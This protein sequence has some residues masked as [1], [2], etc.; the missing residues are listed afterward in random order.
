MWR[1]NYD[2]LFVFCFFL[3][4][5][6]FASAIILSDGKGT[7]V[8]QF[9]T[10]YT[11]CVWNIYKQNKAGVESDLEKILGQNSIIL[12]QEYLLNKTLSPL[13]H[14]QVKKGFWWGAIEAFKVRN[15]FPTGV[16][17]ISNF[18]PFDFFGGHSS[19]VEPITN[20]PKSFIMSKFQ[21]SDSNMHLLVI[22]NHILNFVSTEAFVTNIDQ[23]G[24]LINEHPGPAIWAG[25]FNTWN[26]AR[27]NYL[28]QMATKLGFTKVFIENSGRRV[29]TDHIYIR[30]NIETLDAHFNTEIQSSDHYP[31]FFR[32]RIQEL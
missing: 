32:F 19:L 14:A 4:N 3:L 6:S 5:T 21:I 9:N 17:T 27:M 29:P 28:N 1:G 8:L 26:S 25:D 12:L 11:L 22:N 30:R 10:P 18:E 16:M 7:G 13:L 24:K 2:L 20:T 15:A 31:I 23:I